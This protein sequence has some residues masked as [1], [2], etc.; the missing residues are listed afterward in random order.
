MTGDE[1]PLVPPGNSTILKQLI[2]QA[3][4]VVF[5][6]R[7]HCLLIETPEEFNQNVIDFLSK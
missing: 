3:E 1:D 7:R 5:P 6:K 4:L 2:P